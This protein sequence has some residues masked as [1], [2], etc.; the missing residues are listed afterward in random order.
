MQTCSLPALP[1][2]LG[3]LF[4]FFT[5]IFHLFGEELVGGGGWGVLISL[6]SF[7]ARKGQAAHRWVLGAESETR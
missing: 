6:D 7:T 5:I 4:Y 2:L 1:V 3:N